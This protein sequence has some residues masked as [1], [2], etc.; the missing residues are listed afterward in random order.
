MVPSTPP[1]PLPAEV[2]PPPTEEL[3]PN[4]QESGENPVESPSDLFSEQNKETQM[5]LFSPGKDESVSVHLLT[6]SSIISYNYDSIKAREV[7][8]KMP[9]EEKFDATNKITLLY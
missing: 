1:P 8:H 7:L 4:N 9:K 2:T 3:A 6:I 5:N